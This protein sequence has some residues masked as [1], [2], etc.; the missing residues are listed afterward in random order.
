MLKPK[1]A[2]L[3][4]AFLLSSQGIASAN[5]QLLTGNNQAVNKSNT[6][7]TAVGT[8]T[9]SGPRNLQI[10]NSLEPSYMSLGDLR[11]PGTNIV[12]SVGYEY[13]NLA[14]IADGHRVTGQIALVIPTDAG[15]CKKMF[16]KRVER[17]TALF[18]ADLF[19]KGFTNPEC[20]D[21]KLEPIDEAYL[22]ARVGRFFQDDQ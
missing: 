19:G 5:A 1:H 2:V 22:R 14:G 18:C 8:I 6:S 21:A 10:N 7:Q 3:G 4:A 9:Q 17:S 13:D 20:H 11:C 16:K 15:D 12:P